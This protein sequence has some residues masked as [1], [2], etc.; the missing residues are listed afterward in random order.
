MSATRV[1]VLTP[2]GTGAIAT[3]EVC[4]PRAWE[5]RASTLPARRQAAAGIA[6]SEPLL[7]RYA[8]RRRGRRGDPRSHRRID[9]SE[10]H[11]HGG[12]RVV[13]WVVEQLLA[14]G[15]REP[16]DDSST[17]GLDAPRSPPCSERPPCA[18]RRS[19][20]ISSTARSSGRCRTFSHCSTR[21]PTSRA[22]RFANSPGGPRS[23]G[24]SS[25]PWK[26]VVAGAP[27]VGKSSLVNALA[28]FQRAVVS[29][30]AGTTRDLV[31]VQLAF[32]GWPVELTDTAG[33]RE[34]EGLEAEGVERANRASAEA[35]LVVWVV[36]S[37]DPRPVWPSPGFARGAD[38]PRSPGSLVVGNKS[39]LPF[40]WNADDFDDGRGLL[41]VTAATGAGIAEL[42]AEIVRRL[43]PDP[44]APGVAVPFT[45][46]L[47]DQI[48]GANGALV[49]VR[50]DDAAR[51]LREALA[52]P[53]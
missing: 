25:Q 23:V 18:P 19:C 4:G 49:A 33:L 32:D 15:G 27:N 40:A 10:I 1:A 30:I 3:V 44:P 31:S 14:S 38:A 20:W 39:D 29:E 45:P 16:P 24:I 47:A 35:D 11:C 37:S 6:R 26:V 28:G 52:R 7:V 21:T 2:P 8:R 13:R 46:G 12:R 22:S 5:I 42:V 34:A 50:V 41:R 36:D 51:L 9:A 17:R 48:E 43:V 53:G